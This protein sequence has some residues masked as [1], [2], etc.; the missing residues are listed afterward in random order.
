MHGANRTGGVEMRRTL[1]RAMTGGYRRTALVGAVSV[2]LLAGAWGTAAGQSAPS[3]T[4]NNGTA[5]A[6]AVVARVAP[7]VGALQL[8]ISSGVAVSE[9]KNTVAQSQAKTLDL[10]LLGSTLTQETCGRD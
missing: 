9:I 2:A 3:T 6:T 7:G 10:G 1:Q 8:G 5:K 4:F